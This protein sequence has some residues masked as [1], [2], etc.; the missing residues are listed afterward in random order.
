MSCP[1]KHTSEMGHS[2]HFMAFRFLLPQLMIFAV[3]VNDFPYYFL[4]HP[5]FKMGALAVALILTQWYVRYPTGYFNPPYLALF[6][7]PENHYWY[8]LG[9]KIRKFQAEI[10]YPIV[11]VSR[12]IGYF[13]YAAGPEIYI[14]DPFGLVNRETANP[15][16]INAV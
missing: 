10:D 4:K 12:N 6:K 13:G 9:R 15:I 5:L 3:L 7:D 1:A 16:P 8:K 11:R 14:L 2:S